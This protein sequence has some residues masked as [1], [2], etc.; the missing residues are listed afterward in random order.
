MSHEIPGVVD[1][2]SR[3]DR[4]L[5]IA[6]GVTLTVAGV[7]WLVVDPGYP[8][9]YGIVC[10]LGTVALTVADGRHFR[11]P[12]QPRYEVSD[13]GVPVVVL[14]RGESV[15]RATWAFTMA[16]GG[17]LVMVSLPFVG[18]DWLWVDGVFAS[19]GALLVA[20]SLR[21]W[22]TTAGGLTLTRTHLT[23]EL[24][25][26]RWSAPWSDVADVVPRQNLRIVF[27]A[28][29]RPGI[30]GPLSLPSRWRMGSALGV[31]TRHLAG[32]TPLASYLVERAAVD[33]EFRDRLGDPDL[34]RIGV[35]EG[36]VD[37][38]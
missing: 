3:G 27:E 25:G 14:P 6:V 29:R 38:A 11:H 12:P 24:S 5:L 37:G 20:V 1:P 21:G 32:G 31:Q 19:I 8:A 7:I 15:T 4:M 30:T 2:R 36:V 34:V 17:S 33:P 18:D 9:L 13:Q 35:P 23:H 22:W 28:G 26:V 10:G 16:L